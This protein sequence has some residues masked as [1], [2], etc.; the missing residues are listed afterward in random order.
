[1]P[2]LE[3]DDPVILERRAC[4]DCSKPDTPLDGEGRCDDCAERFLTYLRREFSW[5]E[6]KSEPLT[7]SYAVEITVNLKSRSTQDIRD[8]R[9]R[10]A[11]IL[12]GMAM[13]SDQESWS[14]DLI[15]MNDEDGH[16]VTYDPDGE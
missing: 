8:A 7:I 4:A 9:I 12:L 16:E 13:V 6:T 14:H 5:T 2:E 1:M 10:A 11:E 15:T 3:D